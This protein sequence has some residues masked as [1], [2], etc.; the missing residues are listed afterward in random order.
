MNEVTLK[1][2]LED[3]HYIN[4]IGNGQFTGGI[5]S[6]RWRY[7]SVDYELIWDGKEVIDWMIYS[8]EQTK[9]NLEKSVTAYLNTRC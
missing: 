6:E 9:E 2:I 5:Y 8:P 4:E 7:K 3:G 1:D